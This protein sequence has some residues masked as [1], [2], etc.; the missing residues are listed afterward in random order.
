MWFF[1][2]SHLQSFRMWYFV[3]YFGSKAFPFIESIWWHNHNNI[4]GS[5]SKLNEPK[6]H[7]FANCLLFSQ[8]WLNILFWH[9]STEHF[10]NCAKPHKNYCFQTH[11][12]FVRPLVLVI[13]SFFLPSSWFAHVNF[14]NPICLN[15]AFHQVLGIRVLIEMNI[16]LLDEKKK[17]KIKI[18]F[19]SE[20]TILSFVI[21]I[22]E[23]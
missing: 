3:C 23:K 12:A 1:K 22:E 5:S 4:S 6:R 11:K 18:H 16:I 7:C 15:M 13:H 8:I 10:V 9:C 17:P 20:N 19:N 21:N 14:G 2:C